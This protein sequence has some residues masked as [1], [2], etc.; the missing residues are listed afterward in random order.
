MWNYK[1]QSGSYRSGLEEAVQKYLKHYDIIYDYET[2]KISYTIPA[3]AHTYTPDFVF[4]KLDGTR[5]Y[6]E[7]KGIWDAEDRKKFFYIKK[8]HP[9]LDLR[10]VF[11]NPLEKIRKGSKV[12][13][14]D[15]CSGN[16]RGQANFI[17]PYTRVG[18]YGELP[19]EWLREIKINITGQSIDQVYKQAK[20]NGKER[21]S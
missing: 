3:I 6:I 13:Y 9:K 17:V 14:A 20:D 15:V 4:Y 21:H 2:D 12:T 19:V 7:T 16:L 5:M 10:F 11:S 1:R 18:P 8:E